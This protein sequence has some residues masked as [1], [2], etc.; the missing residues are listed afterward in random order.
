MADRSFK[1]C[2]VGTN[3]PSVVSQGVDYNG[4]QPFARGMRI[5]CLVGT[6]GRNGLDEGTLYYVSETTTIN[7]GIHCV[8]LIDQGGPWAVCRFEPMA[9][10]SR[11]MKEQFE[12]LR[13]KLDILRNKQA[14]INGDIENVVNELH[15]DITRIEDRLRNLGNE[16]IEHVPGTPKPTVTANEPE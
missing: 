9:E 16:E 2:G 13:D 8:N 3:K 15:S 4:T 12:D 1:S 5:Q 11:S 6:D 7:G 14:Y 10:R